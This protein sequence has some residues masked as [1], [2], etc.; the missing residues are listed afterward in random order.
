[1]TKEN[2]RLL[3]RFEGWIDL[4][5]WQRLMFLGRIP[6]SD[7]ITFLMPEVHTSLI[8]R[9]LTDS[10]MDSIINYNGQ[11][12]EWKHATTFNGIRYMFTREKKVFSEGNGVLVSA[13]LSN[14]PLT[15][16]NRVTFRFVEEFIDCY[17]V[18]FGSRD[19]SS[20]LDS[21][22][23]YR[24]K[25][26]NPRCHPTP[27]V[28]DEDIPEMQYY[29]E[30]DQHVLLQ[31][32][33][34]K[35]LHSL[36]NDATY[37][38]EKVNFWMVAIMAFLASTL[39]GTT[40][41]SFFSFFNGVHVDK[42]ESLNKRMRRLFFNHCK[43]P[44]QI[45]ALTTT[46]ASFPT[47]CGYQHVFENETEKD[48]FFVLHPFVMEGLRLCI[49]LADGI[50][51]HFMGSA[52]SHC[53]SLCLLQKRSTGKVT[54]SSL[55]VRFKIFA[56]GNSPK[57]RTAEGNASRANDLGN[58]RRQHRNQR[59]GGAGGEGLGEEGEA[60]GE[61]EEGEGAGEE[62]DENED[63]LED[64][65]GNNSAD[66]QD[67]DDSADGNEADAQAE[68]DEDEPE[69]QWED[70]DD[71]DI[72]DDEADADLVVPLQQIFAAAIQQGAA[73]VSDSEG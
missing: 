9:V 42:S 47:T 54:C 46:G 72:L 71:E 18:G 44:N 4:T 61:N 6:G 15:T 39:I 19:R 68:L 48:D 34:E 67:E 7:V 29:A 69:L 35:I 13:W 21:V 66:G 26:R 3:K 56:W 5:G 31:P 63:D 40:G 25:R 64:S 52:F 16:T 10:E 38:S 36:G 70:D 59:G 1:M 65:D 51:H 17:G 62:N 43:N 37:A 22:N 60:V 14:D 53:T 27:F 8:I 2:A 73:D 20:C 32:I 49:N 12:V 41:Q 24:D 45:R 11:D 57:Q 33:L 55:D 50:C 58:H 28:A 23:C 30:R